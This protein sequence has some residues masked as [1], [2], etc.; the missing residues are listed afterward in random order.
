[1][2]TKRSK[3]TVVSSKRNG[4]ADED[5]DKWQSEDND[6]EKGGVEINGSSEVVKQ[7]SS[8][9]RRRVISNTA[10]MSKQM[11][12]KVTETKRKS[13]GKKRRDLS[14]L[15][16]MPLDILFTICT[17]LSPR[18]LINLSRTDATFCRTLTAN[19]VS[20]VWKAVREAESGIVSPR[21][22]PEYRWV[23][24]LFGKSYCDLCYANH[25]S[26]DWTLRRRVCT[27]C[28]KANLIAALRVK[29]RFPGVNA[30]ALSLIPL[31]NTGRG[32]MCAYNGYYWISDITDI[33]AKIKELEVGPGSSER[34]ANFRKERKKLVEDMTK[35]AIQCKEW[36][37]TNSRKNA[38]ESDLRKDERFSMI[39]T[40]L[41]DLGYTEQ[42]V[43]AV[44]WESSVIRDAELTS[45]SWTRM[46]PSLEAVIKA[47]RVRK[48]KAARSLALRERAS[49]VEDILKTYKQQFLPIVWREMPS[50]ID[51]CMFPAFKD[52]LELPTE[53]I[54]NEASFADAMNEL[55]DLIADWQQRRVSK[56]RALIPSQETGQI[57]PLKL[58]TTVFSCQSDCRAIITD[59]DV[60]WHQCKTYR[61]I[62]RQ[63]ANVDDL[64]NAP[65]NTELSFDTTR[66]VM[67]AS[68]VRLASR[69]PA[70]TTAEDM[71]I[72]K[73][74]FLCMNDPVST[75][76]LANG[77]GKCM[78]RRVLSWRECV[79]RNTSLTY[80]QGSDFRLLTS[81]D[82][83]KKMRV[84]RS[85]FNW[86][87]SLF[88][89]QH[90]TSHVD[91]QRYEHVTKHLQD[92]HGIG[93][94]LIDRDLFLTPGAD[95]PVA[96]CP[97]LYIVEFWRDPSPYAWL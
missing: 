25:A 27:R 11:K 13:T 90:C 57:D 55:P 92:V 51:V 12:A 72:L 58:A 31:T 5:S 67:A 62:G 19:N 82:E 14:L 15:P 85:V 54:I 65:G 71:D 33:Q 80:N 30:D 34:L 91:P 64:Y 93:D 32:G 68:L 23:D 77:E 39:K 22:I 96:Q 18:D 35:G 10:A 24:L 87:S 37:L 4:S 8:V 88:H 41:L 74:E 63:V 47:Y 46:R 59:A 52:V 6:T 75:Y 56:L 44:R 83:V 76:D 2:Q 28:L 45:Q 1:M 26:V 94:P 42:D 21:G 89:C 97:P 61:S 78:G 84:V 81:E 40:R 53:T 60:W 17:M 95:M 49:I 3:A 38:R 29:R 36:T 50:L 69:D 20:F 86:T 16:T 73:L 9:K 7:P 79:Q 70:T 66:S 43:E 48:A